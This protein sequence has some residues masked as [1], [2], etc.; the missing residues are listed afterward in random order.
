MCICCEAGVIRCSDCNCI[1]CDHCG[2][3][4][5]NLYTKE[6][7]DKFEEMASRVLRDDEY[8]EYEKY[9]D[10]IYDLIDKHMKWCVVSNTDNRCQLC[11]EKRRRKIRRK[12]K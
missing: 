12:Q 7:V 1:C 4:L 9:I 11:L 2:E 8:I 5:S 10:L 3:D 6:L